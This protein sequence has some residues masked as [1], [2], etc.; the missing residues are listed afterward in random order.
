[1]GKN[2]DEKF[3]GFRCLLFL[4]SPVISLGEFGIYVSLLV[5]KGKSSVFHLH[6]HW[7]N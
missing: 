2:G 7:H 3:F 6:V 5:L 4:S 1:M